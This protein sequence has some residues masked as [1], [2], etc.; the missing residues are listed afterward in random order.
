MTVACNDIVLC[1]MT[2]IQSIMCDDTYPK[3]NLRRDVLGSDCSGS[4]R[5]LFQC[6]NRKCISMSLYCDFRDDCGDLSDETHCG[7]WC[8]LVKPKMTR[9]HM[10]YRDLSLY[11]VN[12]QY[13]RS[14]SYAVWDGDGV[15]G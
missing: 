4:N 8:L 14:A 15:D 13:D 9:R 3:L 11:Y 10:S 1:V 7:R 12:T 5:R 6:D 2:L